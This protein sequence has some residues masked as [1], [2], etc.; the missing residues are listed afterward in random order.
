MVSE[1]VMLVTER[2]WKVL[3]RAIAAKSKVPAPSH[4]YDIL[5][6]TIYPTNQSMNNLVAPDTKDG[7]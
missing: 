3:V 2:Y 5:E 1:R 7:K 6:K 4:V